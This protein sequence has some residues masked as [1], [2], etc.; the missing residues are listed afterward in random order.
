MIS[1]YGEKLDIC[2]L[3]NAKSNLLV[4]GITVVSNQ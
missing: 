1:N 2:V 4:Y 3:K